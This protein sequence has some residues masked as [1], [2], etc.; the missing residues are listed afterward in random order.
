MD[1]RI[2]GSN[3]GNFLSYVNS[4]KDK[5]DTGAEKNKEV[6][7]RLEKNKQDFADILGDSY[8]GA[9]DINKK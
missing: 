2:E 8:S 9:F 3:L 1:S 5:L 4:V 7:Q 6:K